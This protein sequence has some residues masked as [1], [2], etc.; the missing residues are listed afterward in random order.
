MGLLI[1]DAYV[2]TMDA[3]RRV[4]ADGFVIVDDDG[5]IARVG[6]MNECRVTRDLDVFDGAGMIALPGL[7]NADQQHWQHLVMA[8]GPGGDARFLDACECSLTAAD[9]QI[10]ASLAAAEMLATGTT[11]VLNRLPHGSAREGV[12]STIETIAASGIRQ[13]AAIAFSDISEEDL[14]ETIRH[15]QGA[16]EGRVRVALRLTAD[17]QS[18]VSGVAR[19]GAIERGYGI[20]CEHDI[21]VVSDISRPASHRVVGVD[22]ARR[23]TGRTTILHLM[24][25]G[26]LDSRWILRNASGLSDADA[27]LMANAG[28]SAVHAPVAEALEGMASGAWTRLIQ[29]GVNCALGSGGP[30]DTCCVDML[31]QMKAA[32][33]IQNTVLLDPTALSPEAVLEMATINAARALG[34]D[35]D[36]GSLEPGKRADIAVFDMRAPHFQVINKPISN[37]VCCARGADAR[38]VLVDGRI[39]WRDGALLHPWND[40]SLVQEARH[41]AG[42]LIERAR[43]RPEGTS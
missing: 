13:I 41:R 37:F 17:Q 20:A 38:I 11:C 12:T 6:P 39:V 8:L 5:R 9:L 43:T 27:T 4:H 7:I 35:A 30:G 18:I 32:M 1:R 3:E 29:A 15:W 16:H 36:I 28:C 23:R 19:E 10:A 34:L 24:E 31:E 22:E 42:A 25:L 2:V 33:L 40:D 26:V 21:K 14:Q